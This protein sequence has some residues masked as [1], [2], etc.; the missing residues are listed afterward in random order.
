MKKFYLY[1]LSLLTGLCL[2]FTGCGSDK[3][4]VLNTTEIFLQAAMD[5]DV[6]TVT[7]YCNETV[8]TELG[9]N[10][11]SPAFAETTIYENMQVD[12]TALS[13][14]SQLA[15]SEFCTYYSSNIIQNF[16]LDEAT[17]E[18]GIGTVT[19]TVT[20]YSK[21]ALLALTGDDFQ[22]ELS[23][24]MTTYQEEHMD[25]L[26]S[27]NINDGNEAMLNKL[28]DDL[29][30]EIMGIMKTSY[31]SYTPEDVNITFTL[32]KQNDIWMITNATLGQ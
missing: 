2:T 6:E 3:K 7:K 27:I 16:T 22:T 32:E 9:L 26:I 1:T 4:E 30:P 19:A 17:C 11:I 24:L 28:F 31:D 23:N 8:L 20:T 10:S 14:A 15:V 21:D 5:C 29:M 25:E 12:K 18:D 13:E